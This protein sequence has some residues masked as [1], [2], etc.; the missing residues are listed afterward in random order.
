MSIIAAALA[1][2]WA[3]LALRRLFAPAAPAAP[4][5]SG[6]EV[7]VADHVRVPDGDVAVA[8]V[9]PG[10]EIDRRSLAIASTCLGDPEVGAV[11]P[12][13]RATTTDGL[14]ARLQDLEWVGISELHVRRGQA[15]GSL[16]TG[17]GAPVYRA[18][19]LRR[20]DPLPTGDVRVAAALAGAGWRLVPCHRSVVR[21]VPAS[22]FRRLFAARVDAA[23]ELLRAVPDGVRLLRRQPSVGSALL[24]PVGLLLVGALLAA[25]LVAT[26]LDPGRTLDVVGGWR[27]PAWYA[28]LFAPAW[29]AGVAYWSRGATGMASA[30]AL[31]HVFVVWSLHWV[32]AMWVALLRLPFR[33]QRSTTSR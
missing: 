5:G 33:R 31:G 21:R 29:V 10:E 7:V 28:V 2:L 11:Q 13:I 6:L 17:P 26:A 19:A 18:E 9:G 23:T 22:S 25:A 24:A 27:A 1:V 20:L 16:G 4:A 14:L 30:V 15:V 8:V 12:S 32:V 3:A